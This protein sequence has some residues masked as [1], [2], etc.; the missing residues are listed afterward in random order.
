MKVFVSLD[1]MDWEIEKACRRCKKVAFGGPAGSS[2][3]CTATS[4]WKSSR[5]RASLVLFI[6]IHLQF[7]TMEEEYDP[8]QRLTIQVLGL[9]F[10]ATRLQSS[11]KRLP[12]PTTELTTLSYTSYHELENI[13]CSL[14]MRP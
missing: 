4:H 13:A 3:G 11:S 7:L 1:E 12:F 5:R 9:L 2:L 6:N 8:V 10:S 14:C